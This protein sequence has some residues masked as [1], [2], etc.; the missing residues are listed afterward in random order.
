[1]ETQAVKPKS[2]S[3]SRM[4]KMREKLKQ[5]DPDYQKNENRRISDLK[6]QNKV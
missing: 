6:K 4:K 2:T 5:K 3:A 1:M